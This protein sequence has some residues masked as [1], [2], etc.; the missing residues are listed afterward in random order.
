MTNVDGKP[1]DIELEVVFQKAA[2]LNV[3]LFLHPT[4]P[5]N[6]KWMGDFRL[7]PIL[8]FGVDTSLAVLRI[9][10]S[11]LLERLPGL[12]LIASH[13]GGVYP[14]L[15]GRIDTGFVA[16]PECKTNIKE[17]PSTYL[18]NIWVDSII[19]DEDVM[20]STLA[21]LGADKIVLGSDHPHQIG[22]MARCV[23]RIESLNIDDEDKEK[24]LR[25]NAEKI[26]KF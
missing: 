12:K 2:K 17:L 23:E 18:K 6:S 24:I 25:K 19:Y 8:G 9:I 13:L 1:L 5:I 10:F 4:S 26:L 21:F 16:Y 7:V 22:D 3:P 11:G 14:Y 20:L 15:R